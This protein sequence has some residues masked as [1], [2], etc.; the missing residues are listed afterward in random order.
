MDGWT[1]DPDTAKAQG[2]DAPLE[3][4]IWPEACN[5]CPPVVQ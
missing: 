1:L 3:L 4:L 2:T 5:T